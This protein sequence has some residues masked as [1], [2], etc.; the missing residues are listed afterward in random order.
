MNDSN[1]KVVGVLP[2]GTAKIYGHLGSGNVRPLL[3]TRK[4]STYGAARLW[5]QE[6]EDQQRTIAKRARD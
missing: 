2:D 3:E 4:F 5:A 1:I 6:Y